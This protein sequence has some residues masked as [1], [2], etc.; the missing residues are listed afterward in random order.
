MKPF[1]S[2]PSHKVKPANQKRQKADSI[3]R[4]FSAKPVSQR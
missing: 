1:K 4:G 2:K 3:P